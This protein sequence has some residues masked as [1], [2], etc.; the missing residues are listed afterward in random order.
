M[1]AT[2]LA[3]DRHKT[4]QGILAYLPEHLHIPGKTATWPQQAPGLDLSPAVQLCCRFADK[5][6]QAHTTLSS[7]QGS[8]VIKHTKLSSLQGRC[9]IRK[10]KILMWHSGMGISLRHPIPLLLNPFW[11]KTRTEKFGG[12]QSPAP[13]LQ[14]RTVTWRPSHCLGYPESQERRPAWGLT[15]PEAQV[16]HALEFWTLDIGL[17]RLRFF[18]RL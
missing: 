11:K 12:I 18:H 14:P 3:W 16:S 4:P 10:K 15:K 8:H 13:S 6:T 5:I 1:K 2:L 7:L 17:S 9:V